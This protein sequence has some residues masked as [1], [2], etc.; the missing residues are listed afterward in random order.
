[1]GQECSKHRRYEE[2]VK[3]VFEKPEGKRARGG[4]V[5]RRITTKFISL[6][7]TFF[8]F[9]TGPS[10]KAPDTLLIVQNSLGLYTDD[11]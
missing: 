11:T 5:S 10:A 6:I 4:S 7:K 9:S 2:C 1:M 3:K 8:F